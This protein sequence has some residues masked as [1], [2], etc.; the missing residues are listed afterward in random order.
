MRGLSALLAINAMAICGSAALSNP[1]IH[2]GSFAQSAMQDLMPNASRLPAG[3]MKT[4]RGRQCVAQ[5]KREALK[6]RRRKTHRMHCRG[7]AS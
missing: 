7:S 3:T 1:V 4:N 5:A 6:L 2:S